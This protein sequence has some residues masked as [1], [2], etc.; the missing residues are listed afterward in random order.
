MGR[1]ATTVLGLAI[2]AAAGAAKA[3]ACAWR[4][5]EVLT[6]QGTVRAGGLDGR[7]LRRA[8]MHSGRLYEQTDLGVVRSARGYDGRLAW[9][10]DVSGATHYLDSSFAR[11]LS[12][13]QAWLDARHGCALEAGPGVTRLDPRSQGARRFDVWRI[14]PAGGAPFEVWQDAATGRPDRAIFRTAETRLIRRFDDWR[15]VAPGRWV[16]FVQRDEF[17]EDEDETLYRIVRAR[18]APRAAAA[19]FARPEAPHDVRMRNGRTEAV[20][21]FEDDHRTRVYVPV[22]LDGKGPFTLELDS[23]GHFILSEETAKAVGLSAQGAF[24]NTGAGNAIGHSGF[25]R[26]AS[27][28]IGDAEVL[29]LPA[30][31]RALAAA[32]NDRGPAPL[33]AGIL[34]LEVFERFEVGIDPRG[35]TVRLRPLGRPRPA[36]RGTPLRLVFAEDAPLVAGSYRGVGGD[37]MLDTGNAGATIVE[38]FWAQAHGLTEG[39]KRG[40]PLAGA[41]LSRGEVGIGPFALAGE[42]VS[43]YGPAERGSEYTRAVAGV[44][45]QPLL[46]RFNAT[47]DYRR[48]KVWLEP[49]GEAA[50]M[51]ANRAGV[52]VAR[53]TPGGPLSVAAV[54]PGAPG[55]EAGLKPGD[56]IQSIDGRPAAAFS[57]ADA[58]A[59]FLQP[60][61]TVVTLTVGDGATP[62]SLTLR[63]LVSPEVSEK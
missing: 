55:A 28:R 10:Q 25:A 29:G 23:G 59:R 49:L 18:L 32:A 53:A 27:L 24:N 63:E 58:Q 52:L 11:A 37:F 9:S 42:T 8:E 36:P 46:S 30:Q 57:R 6:L 51:P 34:G 1:I 19:D 14:A 15:E 2:L 38:D 60:V 40:L 39:L 3:D 44:Y 7:F 41:A 26:I 17:P 45:G 22:Y 4:A 35:K 47:Y 54:A 33:R 61:G 21:P 56:V 50:A 16:A 31:V 12:V 48:G 20:V 43:Y 5:G 13:S 62:A